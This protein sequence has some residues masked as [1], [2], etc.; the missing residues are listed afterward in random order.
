M[1]RH[2]IVRIVAPVLLAVLSGAALAQ[3]T[4]CEPCQRAWEAL[5]ARI[6][7]IPAF[8]SPRDSVWL[9]VFD[10]LRRDPL[11]LPRMLARQESPRLRRV[12]VSVSSWS[13][14]I[15]SV[16]FLDRLQAGTYV[17][18]YFEGGS[19]DNVP[20]VSLRFVVASNGPVDV[21][22]YF[23]ATLGHYFITADAMEI[24]K[25]DSGEIAGWARTGESFHALP[26]D[27]LPSFGLPVCRYY[28]LP[29]V[30]LDTHFFSASA[31]ECAFVKATWPNQWILESDAAFGS[32]ASQYP[33]ECSRP[34][35]RLYNNRP[36]ANH[37]YTTSTETRDRMIAQG[38]IL[39]AA[40]SDGPYEDPYSMCVLP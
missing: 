38:W 27:E 14:D 40:P 16:T 32:I 31:D 26:A 18:D 23:N 21:V 7:P 9:A 39:E 35:Y 15:A 1:T 37:R 10:P 5:P 36:D 3:D 12:A 17:V 2:R 29:S 6:V 28:G 11:A 24:A 25:L 8:P 19:T 4:P 33:F 34:L 13:G 30:G 22:E 20:K